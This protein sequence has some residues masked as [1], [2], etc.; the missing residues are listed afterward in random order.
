MI[1]Y[2]NLIEQL[3]FSAKFIV[4]SIL[5]GTLAKTFLINYFIWKIETTKQ[6]KIII[7]KDG[8]VFTSSRADE[9]TNLKIFKSLNEET[10]ED[11]IENHW[12]DVG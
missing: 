10:S 12:K 7:K 11:D 5:V 1:D 4:L 8:K 6:S 2:N 9:S 3:S